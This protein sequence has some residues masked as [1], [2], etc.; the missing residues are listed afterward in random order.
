MDYYTDLT[1]E[2]WELLTYLFK[3]LNNTGEYLEKQDKWQLLN[4]VLYLK[5]TGCQWRL[6][7]N[8]F[9][10]YSTISFFIIALFKMVCGKKSIHF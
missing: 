6:L 5:K 8:D 10:N 1:N 9:S 4:A 3:R 2:Q 7:P